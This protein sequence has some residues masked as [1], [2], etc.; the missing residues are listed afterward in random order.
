MKTHHSLQQVLKQTDW[1]KLSNTHVSNV[2]SK[3]ARCRTS[4]LGY[5]HYRC[6]NP[7]CSHTHYQYHSCR[8]RH[9]PVCNWQKQQAWMEARLIELLPVKYFHVVFTL[10]HEF[11]A[12]VMG[13]R[14]LLFK[15][16]FDSA[17]HC[18]LTLG[19]DPKWL[20]AT[21]SI[22]AVLHTWGQQLSFHPHVHCIVSGGGVDEQLNWIEI[23]KKSGQGYLFP[24]QVMEPLFKK[25]F[26]HQVQKMISQGVL[27]ITA[28]QVT[29][30]PWLKDA[31]YRKK[32]VVYAKSPMRGAAQVV[33]YLARYAHK[34]A[35]SNH[36][37]VEVTQE[38]VL[39]HYK[40]YNDNGTTKQMWLSAEE[41]LRRYAEHI[42]PRGFVKMRHYGILANANRHSRINRIL[43]KMNL[44]LHPPAVEVPYQ[45]RLLE[46][47][48]I[49][50]DRCPKC[51]TGRMML[52]G[53][54]Y[55][56]NRGSPLTPSFSAVLK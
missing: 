1:C 35:I 16:L 15:L 19:A 20:G 30:W 45:L 46:R 49:D 23:K 36:R 31:L 40:D 25:H 4:H 27:N 37:I 44:P 7:D 41:F 22:T 28:E 54:L 24:Y 5:H 14:V 26:L 17:A 52:T 48:G 10:P 29:Q 2:F 47:Y 11:N 13:N 18:L 33:E 21:P 12:M 53:V 32:W 50:I 55:P 42:L 43:Q 34:V 9:C 56:N 51:K 39:F 6:N 38:R 8:N 3:L